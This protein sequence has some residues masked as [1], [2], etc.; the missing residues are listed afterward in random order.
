MM[1]EKQKAEQGSSGGKVWNKKVCEI[2]ISETTQSEKI[3][4]A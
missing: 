4:L 1:G 3:V 2:N